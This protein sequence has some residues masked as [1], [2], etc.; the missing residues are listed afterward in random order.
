M[1]VASLV[2]VKEIRRLWSVHRSEFFIAATA[3]A[4]VLWAGLL[5]GVLIGA[6]ISLVLLVRR[7][8]MPHVAI[9]GK[10]PGTDRYSDQSRHEKNEPI[11]DMLVFRVESGI[12]YFNAEH[13]SDA[14]LAGVHA[15]DQP[16]HHV[17]C[18]LS[19]SPLVDMAGARMLINLADELARHG[20]TLHVV[21]A[22]STV[23]DMLRKEGGEKTFGAINRFTTLHSTIENIQRVQG[24]P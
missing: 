16:I 1:A 3:L 24:A 20:I 5:Q 9:L 22:R 18:D 17:L 14:V 7:A 8:S 2:K 4:G 19:N 6:I 11:P 13:I 10:I 23:R 21:E 12:L 15:S